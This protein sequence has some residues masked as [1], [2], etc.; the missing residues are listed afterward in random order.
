MS[1]QQT[2]SNSQAI[3]DD[4]EK[5]ILFRDTE[6]YK[7]I[8]KLPKRFPTRVNDVY[9]TNKTDFKAQLKRC[10][11]LLRNKSNEIYIHAMGNSINR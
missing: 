10:E 8:K 9:I 5:K 3:A 7:I 6:E 1:N 4:I 11:Y 2:V